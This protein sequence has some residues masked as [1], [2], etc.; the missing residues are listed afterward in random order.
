MAALSR[1]ERLPAEIFNHILGYLLHHE[2]VERP[3]TGTKYRGYDFV[4]SVFRL[5]SNISKISLS[6]FHLDNRWIRIETNVSVLEF[7]PSNLGIP[8]ID[9]VWMSKLAK[10]PQSVLTAKAFF[11]GNS[12]RQGHRVGNHTRP[13]FKCLVL[14]KDLLDFLSALR[15]NDLELCGGKMAPSISIHVRPKAPLNSYKVLME[16]LTSYSDKSQADTFSVTVESL[17]LSSWL[18]HR[19]HDHLINARYYLAIICSLYHDVSI[20]EINW[21]ASIQR[22]FEMAV[23]ANLCIAR[24]KCDWAN[25][26]PLQGI[27]YHDSVSQNSWASIFHGAESMSDKNGDIISTNTPFLAF[28]EAIIGSQQILHSNRNMEHGNEM[29]IDALSRLPPNTNSDDFPRHQDLQLWSTWLP[30]HADARQKHLP[31]RE[32]A[33]QG[34]R[35]W[36][37][38]L[39]SWQWIIHE[40]DVLVEEFKKE[41]KVVEEGDTGHL[42]K[43]A[44]DVADR[45]GRWYYL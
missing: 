21:I 13:D 31:H 38:G 22:T 24:A 29:I 18:H 3:A 16:T 8:I 12:T 7:H 15:M 11:P 30:R 35:D 10:L 23:S 27:S 39:K 26:N 5:N 25:S 41:L 44:W 33:I 45:P 20:S 37:Q 1:L 4:T 32:E 2:N 28:F 9:L 34:I 6:A 36:M 17:K 42:I 14:P 19:A 43:F 40:D